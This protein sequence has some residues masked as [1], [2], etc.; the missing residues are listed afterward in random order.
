[1]GYKEADIQIHE[2]SIED[3]EELLARLDQAFLKSPDEVFSQD[4]LQACFLEE[5][6]SG[7]S[8]DDGLVIFEFSDEF[9][10]TG[11]GNCFIKKVDPKVSLILNFSSRN[12]NDCA[13]IALELRENENKNTLLK[14]V[15]TGDNTGC[16]IG[17]FLAELKAVGLSLPNNFDAHLGSFIKKCINTYN[18]LC[19]QGR[20]VENEEADIQIAE[21]TIE[22]AEELLNKIDSLLVKTVDE[23]FLRD[24]LDALCSGQLFNI[25]SMN[26]NQDSIHFLFSDEF[27]EKGMGEMYIG[28]DDNTA[29]FIFILSFYSR[30][31]N[32]FALFNLEL[33]KQ[34]NSLQGS[35]LSTFVLVGD[36]GC[37]L[38][39]FLS[40]LEEMGLSFPN[41]F[42]EHLANFIGKCINTYN[43]LCEEDK[44][45]KKNKKRKK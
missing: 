11:K 41:N 38:G 32:D 25:C 37:A 6:I 27:L 21:G 19:E 16:S 33:K 30:T 36:A 45:R 9:I 20:V 8:F 18:S 4:D 10:E 15:S 12:D 17:E 13:I 43:S 31:A 35:P 28:I 26:S 44:S 34:D 2:G 29:G 23:L 39:D 5:D 7:I 24:D 3:A 1:M 40:K 22:D 42:G 14:F